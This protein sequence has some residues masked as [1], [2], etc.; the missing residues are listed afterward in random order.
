[1]K[2][3][4]SASA[5]ITLM[6]MVI[7]GVSTA[8]RQWTFEDCLQYAIEH[9]IDIQQR[10]IDIKIQENERNSANNEVLPAVTL[11]AGQ[12]F[13][14]GNALAATGTMPASTDNFDA[15]LSYTSASIGLEMPIFNGFRTKNH[16]LSAHYSLEQATAN[17]AFARK[18]LKIQIATY[19]LQALYERGMVRIGQEQVATSRKLCERARAL[20]DDGRNPMSD[21]AQAEAQLADDEY[22]LTVYK[23]RERMALLTL[24]QLLNLE[25]T[26]DFAVADM[27]ATGIS[28][29]SIQSVSLIGE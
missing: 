5:L 4:S 21:L 2:N 29:A 28:T 9:N 26:H 3:K 13:S 6:L 22:N 12:Q 27:D 10:A 11:N 17:M 8:Q 20:V 24:A 16:K 15:D 7:P 18:S 19:Y 1:M 23:G 25:N 14:F